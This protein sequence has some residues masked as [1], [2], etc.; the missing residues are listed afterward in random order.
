MIILGIETSTLRVGAALGGAE[1]VLA[2]FQATRD[3]RHAEALAP[4]IEFI[5]RQARVEMGEISAVAVDI[6]PGLFTG[7]RVGVATAKAMAQALR[8]PMIGLSSLDLLAFTVRYSDRLVVPVI[9][10]R[11]GEV[12]CATYRQVPGGIQRLS[13]YR[14]SSPSDLAG[15]LM[16]TGRDSLLVG[17]GALRYAEVFTADIGAELG[18]VGTA[19]PSAGALV[20]LAQPRAIREEF[21]PPSELEVFYLRRSD[22][23]INWDRRQHPWSGEGPDDLGEAG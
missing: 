17:D 11:R 1:G 14:L 8:V 21:V 20:E 19:Y 12:Y 3:R 9:D 2:E 13:P 6:G 16:A 23:E 18:T 15:E 7:L 4:A 22:A 5:C 10:A